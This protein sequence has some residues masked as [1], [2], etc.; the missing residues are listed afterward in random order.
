M[1]SGATGRAEETTIKTF[2]ISAFPFG[3]SASKFL[4]DQSVRNGC[5]KVSNSWCFRQELSFK[6]FTILSGT[7]HNFANFCI[8]SSI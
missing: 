1:L 3:N 4:S 5:L 8:S 7:M 2:E 6:S